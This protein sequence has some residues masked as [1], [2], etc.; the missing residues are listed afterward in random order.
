MGNLPCLNQRQ[1]LL[2]YV[3]ADNHRDKAKSD[4]QT[5]KEAKNFDIVEV[6]ISEAV[7]DE[8]QDNVQVVLHGAGEKRVS[9]AVP[10]DETNQANLMDCHWSFALHKGEEDHLTV[11]CK[12]VTSPVFVGMCTLK[13]HEAL[14]QEWIDIYIHDRQLKSN[15]QVPVSIGKAQVSFLKDHQF[16]LELVGF[17]QSTMRAK[18][19]VKQDGKKMKLVSDDYELGRTAK[20]LYQGDEMFVEYIVGGSQIIGFSRFA[21]PLGDS[22]TNASIQTEVWV[23]PS[24]SGKI[25]V[26]LQVKPEDR[27]VLPLNQYE[28]FKGLLIVGYKEVATLLAWRKS[29]YYPALVDAFLDVM[30]VDLQAPFL[31]QVIKTE[32]EKMAAEEMSTIFRANSFGTKAVEKFQ[33]QLCE[34]AYLPA[35]YSM[36]LTEVM[37][38]PAEERNDPISLLQSLISAISRVNIPNQL[39]RLYS[40]IR[41]TV[42]AVYPFPTY[43]HV[44]CITSFLF[45]RLH[46]PVLLN[47]GLLKSANM[48][49]ES[50]M[51][52]R[53]LLVTLLNNARPVLPKLF[54]KLASLTEFDNSDPMAKQ[55]N[56]QLQR[57]FPQVC[58]IVMK[59]V[60]FDDGDM[61]AAMEPPM[62]S[63]DSNLKQMH[64]FHLHLYFSKLVE[65]YSTD[66]H[67][68]QDHDEDVRQ[69]MLSTVS[70]TKSLLRSTPIEDRPERTDPDNVKDVR[71]WWKA[72]C[73]CITDLEGKEH[74]AKELID[75][76]THESIIKLRRLSLGIQESN[77][78]LDDKNVQ[79][80]KSVN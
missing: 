74:E 72:M 31:G 64:L 66:D 26:S 54:A 2:E 71:L 46:L 11:I 33:F 34:K 16:S 41:H 28:D 79:K 25:K 21:L 50:G 40:Y 4:V 1:C 49:A 29:D 65:K 15:L 6:T 42:S 57:L 18:V 58:L 73:K 38:R 13:L 63:S 47:S 39:R 36:F 61:S 80:R 62:P 48:V 69:S 5:P 53:Q 70:S 12:S 60:E 75:Q 17:D 30:G 68:K 35:V 44:H 37:G 45:L 56:N 22:V 24:A 7:L 10:V 3:T 67:D 78:A 55:Y 32:I 76:T 23:R 77:Q 43:V 20:L 19:W 9:M 52:E 51:E 27:P 59:A 8:Q 14:N